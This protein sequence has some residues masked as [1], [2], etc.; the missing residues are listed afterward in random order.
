MAGSEIDVELDVGSIADLRGGIFSGERGELGGGGGDQGLIGGFVVSGGVGSGAGGGY[1]LRGA[2]EEFDDVGGVEDVLIESGE[3]EN[4]VAVER[5]AD[6]ASELLLAVVRLERE[7]GVGGT[8]RTVAQVIEGG[9]MHAIGA[10]LGD[11]ADDGATGAAL[12]GAVRIRGDA[13]FLHDFGGEFE[14][15][16]IASARLGEEALL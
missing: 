8:E 16:A 1:D 14:G 9:A 12:F 5:A 6:G 2:V 3:E 15:S 7:E 11:D 10:G 4:F 13:E